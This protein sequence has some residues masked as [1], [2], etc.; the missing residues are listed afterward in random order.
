MS[1]DSGEKVRRRTAVR[2]LP[3]D[4]R[5]RL[6]LLHGFDP[7]DRER[8]YWFTVGGGIDPGESPELAAVRELAEEVGLVSEPSALV[9][10]LGRATIEFGFDAVRYVQD[11]TYYALRV[12][13]AP[14]SFAGQDAIEQASIDSHAWWTI[15]D[16]RGTTERVYPED[17]PDLLTR[18]VVALSRPG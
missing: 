8:P 10:P 15:D 13:D 7:A 14:I 17:L 2:V 9:G 11:Q 3:L 16:L 5:D 1:G 4:G 6:L 18:A 12:D